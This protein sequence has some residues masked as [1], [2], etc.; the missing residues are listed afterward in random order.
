[1]RGIIYEALCWIMWGHFPRR[2]P[3]IVENKWRTR[4]SCWCGAWD[5]VVDGLPEHPWRNR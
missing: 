1:M 3:F 4:I 5:I 2:V